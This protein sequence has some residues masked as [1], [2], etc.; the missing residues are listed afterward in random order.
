MPPLIME[1]CPLETTLKRLQPIS[2]HS[3]M[4]PGGII[5]GIYIDRHRPRVGLSIGLVDPPEAY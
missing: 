3:I 1:V 5:P 4:P 2:D